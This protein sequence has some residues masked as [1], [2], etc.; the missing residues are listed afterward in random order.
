RA[1]M[2]HP[3]DGFHPTPNASAAQ[4]DMQRDYLMKQT[5]EY[6]AKIDGLDR[7]L[8]Q[9]QAER[10][11]IQATVGK[12]SAIVPIVQ[13]RVDIRKVSSDQEYTSKFQYLEMM[14]LLVEQQQELMVQRSRLRETQASVGALTEARA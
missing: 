3:I 14:Q 13:Q 2:K 11:T 9:K 8:E 10:D 7:Q 4:V 6:R 1:D 12:L 5:A